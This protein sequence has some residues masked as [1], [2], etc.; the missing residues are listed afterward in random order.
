LFFHF[1]TMEPC[2]LPAT[3]TATP[4]PLI[5][6]IGLDSVDR[7]SHLWRAFS[8]PTI[9]SGVSQTQVTTLVSQ[10]QVTT[11]VTYFVVEKSLNQGLIL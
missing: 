4:S 3:L 10:T 8:A 11:L 7:H 1:Q 2:S 6:L 5:A 9:V